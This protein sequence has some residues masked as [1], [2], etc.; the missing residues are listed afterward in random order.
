ML[1]Y[2]KIVLFFGRNC[3]NHPSLVSIPQVTATYS[4]EGTAG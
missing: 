1:L 3:E 2:V 4:A